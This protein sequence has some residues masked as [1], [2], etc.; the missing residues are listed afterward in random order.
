MTKEEI[1]A[2]IAA[3]IA[4][5]F[6][7][8]DIS[9]KLA[10]ILEAI[11]D[12]MPSIYD[13]TSKTQELFSSHIIE[14]NDGEYKKLYD[15]QSLILDPEYTNWSDSIY[16]LC[17]I[18]SDVYSA[19]LSGIESVLNGEEVTQY[20]IFKIWGNYSIYVTETNA[21]EV[22]ALCYD[23][24]NDKCYLCQVLHES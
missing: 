6:N 2:S 4:G 16:P 5:Q 24:E 22:V 20:N 18:P 9:G 23:E 1:K 7:Q 11:V 19:V 21:I 17:T 3:N 8:I 15:A 14:I 10:G 12:W 13:L